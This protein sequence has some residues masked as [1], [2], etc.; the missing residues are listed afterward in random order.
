MKIIRYKYNTYNVIDR[1]YNNDKLLFE[2]TNLNSK[3]RF[4]AKEFKTNNGTTLAVNSWEWGNIK[5]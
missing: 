3:N 2:Q 1:V 4:G 5:E